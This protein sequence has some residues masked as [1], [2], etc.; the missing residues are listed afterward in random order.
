MPPQKPALAGETAEKHDASQATWI[1]TAR[2]VAIV[3]GC[4]ISVAAFY[5]AGV[6][7][8]QRIHE[9]LGVRS[10]WRADDLINKITQAAAPV[11]ALAAFA[12]SQ[13]SVNAEE[14]GKFAARAR[15][16]SPVARLTW[17]RLVAD[18]ERDSFVDAVRRDRD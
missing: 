10:D 11:Q 1:A 12:A 16:D 4:G 14:F 7:E 8:R 9:T 18:G 15:A 2:V 5:W 3:V 6:R 13:A 17:Y